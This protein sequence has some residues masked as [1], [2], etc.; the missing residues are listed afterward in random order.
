[1]QNL[2]GEVIA[3]FDEHL[4]KSCRTG[5]GA[6]VYRSSGVNTIPAFTLEELHVALKQM[7]R[8]KAADT[9]GISAEMLVMDC[10][11]LLDIILEVFNDVLRPAGEVPSTWRSS[12][13]VV[14]FK[15]GDPALPS[16]YRPIAIVP[17]LYK[18]FSRMLCGRIKSSITGQQSVDQAAYRNGFS[19]EDHLLAL[20]LL[21]ETCAEWNLHLWLGLVDFE[22]AFNTVEHAPL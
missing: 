8:G 13:L 11:A 3:C 10:P 9:S 6:D 20:T 16:N 4:Y 19:T 21:L 5:N 17:I 1:M 22:K 7:R 18:L 12:R 15:K 2:P 14:I